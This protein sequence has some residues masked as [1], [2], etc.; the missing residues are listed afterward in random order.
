MLLEEFQEKFTSRR[1]HNAAIPRPNNLSGHPGTVGGRVLHSPACEHAITTVGTRSNSPPTA[2]PP[3]TDAHNDVTLPETPVSARPRPASSS[4][5]RLPPSPAPLPD[6]PSQEPV[7]RNPVCDNSPKIRLSL[8]QL[9][10]NQKKSGA[11]MSKI[12]PSKT[13]TS[14]K[15]KARISTDAASPKRRRYEHDKPP[16]WARRVRDGYVFNEG[17]D[18][19]SPDEDC[20]L[21][22]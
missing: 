17:Q 11:G 9:P 5:S 20:S 1:R 19:A 2:Y 7:D 14:Q 3:S 4:S 15:R 16:P 10:K 6:H 22:Q 18:D 8:E 12:L 13:A 21:R